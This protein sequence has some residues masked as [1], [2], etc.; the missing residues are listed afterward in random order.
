[1]CMGVG[2]VCVWE[3]EERE[4]DVDGGACG[5]ERESK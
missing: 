5:S 3:M 1:M 2:C 4:A